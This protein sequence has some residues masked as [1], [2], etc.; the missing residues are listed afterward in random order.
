MHRQN[1]SLT[2]ALVMYQNISQNEVSLL[3]ILVYQ[4]PGRAPYMNLARFENTTWIY[5]NYVSFA[6][7]S[8]MYIRL[9]GTMNALHDIITSM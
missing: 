8:K 9:P 6:R 4:T 1:P 3:S 7:A 2:T 5:E